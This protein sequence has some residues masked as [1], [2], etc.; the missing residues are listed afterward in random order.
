MV[1]DSMVFAGRT[2][3]SPVVFMTDELQSH[4]I[5]RRQ[6]RQPSSGERYAGPCV[7]RGATPH[8]AHWIQ[9]RR[10]YPRAV[11]MSWGGEA[12]VSSDR[13]R[14]ARPAGTNSAQIGALQDLTSSACSNRVAISGHVVW[15]CRAMRRPLSARDR[16]IVGSSRRLAK[17]AAR[18][19][20]FRGST[21]NAASLHT[22]RAKS[23]SL[24]TIGV[25]RDMDS[26]YVP[27][28]DSRSVGRT[29][30]SISL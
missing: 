15:C 16:P 3:L 24:V 5:S 22:P 27:E 26:R 30:A 10:R 4:S 9:R 7:G 21:Y 6:G 13:F 2:P 12:C 28:Y 18:S 17:A 19:L 25:P 20:G 1:G 14:H 11:L 8:P 23:E 29:K